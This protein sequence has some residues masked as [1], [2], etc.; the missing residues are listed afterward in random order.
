MSDTTTPVT[1]A[2]NPEGK[3]PEFDGEFDAERAK[4]AIADLRT[5]VAS[6][7]DRLASVTADRDAFKEAAEKT[8]T[9]RDEALA[10]AVERAEAAERTLAIAKH[11]LPDDVVAEFADYLTGTAEEVDAKAARLA[12]RLAPKEEQ[13]PVAKEPEVVEP[14]TPE[15]TPPVVPQRPKAALVPG[16]GSEAPKPF[17]AKAIAEKVRG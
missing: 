1:P 15:V 17:D 9:D 11:N 13:A 2:E 3:A 5:E 16:N 7:K 14:V 8:G 4:K 12:A 6:F 10:K